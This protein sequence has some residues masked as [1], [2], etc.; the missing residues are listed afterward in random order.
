M[1]IGWGSNRQSVYEGRVEVKH[2]GQWGTVCGDSWDT[3]DG[4]V[5]CQQIFGLDAEV[6]IGPCFGDCQQPFGWPGT[7]EI[8]LDDLY[9]TGSE[10]ALSLCH[11][12]A[13]GHNCAVFQAAGV[14]CEQRHAYVNQKGACLG[15]DVT[16]RHL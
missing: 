7:D 13:S 4:K 6:A 3:N 12:R 15:K 16:A 11:R 9:C 10:A 1:D 8:W 2:Q 5:V 14:R